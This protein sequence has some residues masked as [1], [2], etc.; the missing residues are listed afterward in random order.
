[1]GSDV[2][3][4]TESPFSPEPAPENATGQPF[5]PP[6][7][8]PAPAGVAGRPRYLL[9]A[10]LFFVTLFT[11][12]TMGAIFYLWIRTD[13]TYDPGELG[14]PTVTP[15]TVSAVWQDGELL[16]IG[17]S[18]SLP[19]LLILFCH[20][21]GHYLACR[22]YRLPSTLPYF[23]PAPIF[24]G[25]LGAFIRI[26]SRIGSR[27]ELLDVGIAGPLAGLIPLLPIL[28]YGV[29]QSEPARIYVAPDEVEPVALILVP[30]R[31]LMMVLVSRFLHGPLPEHTIL[32]LHPFALAAWAG[33]LVTGINLLPIGQLDGGHVLYS[34]IGRLQHRIAVPLW[35]AL[36]LTCLMSAAWI[37]MC[38]LLLV[39][40][41]RHPPVYDE[42]HPLDP[43]RRRLAIAAL[44]LF[45]L[46]FMPVP[47]E[48]FWLAA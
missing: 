13:M 16:S 39:I 7:R 43:L 17:L 42:H 26:K 12:T 8:T 9:A 4:P 3:S 27:K 15:R 2:E 32:D 22:H 45:I 48:Q 11:T 18:F 6:P 19:F 46:C 28:V 44:G 24:I 14:F 47:I 25:T 5:S 34:M 29:A 41:L 10:L 33:L 21:M 37:V 1:M 40:G 35:I 23:L 20:E 31:S 38:V 36:C 30:G